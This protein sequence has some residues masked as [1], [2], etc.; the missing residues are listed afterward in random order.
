MHQLNGR[1]GFTMD[2]PSIIDVDLPGE[3]YGMV[4]VG[5]SRPEKWGFA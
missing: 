3:W 5:S 2:W 4:V 1:P